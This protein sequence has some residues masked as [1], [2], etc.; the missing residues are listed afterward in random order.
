MANYNNMIPYIIPSLPKEQKE[1]LS[2]NVKTSLL[3]TKVI[4]SNWEPFIKLGVHEIYS[5]KMPYA[6][7]KLDYPVDMGGYHHPRDPKNLY[8]FIWFAL[9]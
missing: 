1:A 8:V 3:H 5:P 4:I 9:L 6:R 7:T 2:K